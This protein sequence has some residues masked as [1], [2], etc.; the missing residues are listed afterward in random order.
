MAADEK[1]TASAIDFEVD[2]QSLEYQARLRSIHLVDSIRTGLSSLALLCG[3]AILGFS[4]DTIA[5]YDATHV[6]QAFDLPLWPDN[7]DL[8]P[9]VALVVCSAFVVLTNATSLAFA[10]IQKVSARPFA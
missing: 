2:S 1:T 10:K 4:A 9:S 3:L 8:R 5:V 6:S 7:F